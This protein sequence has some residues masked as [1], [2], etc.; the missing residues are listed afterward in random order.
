MLVS[1]RFGIVWSGA[2]VLLAAAAL[3]ACSGNGPTLSPDAGSGAGAGM[4]SLASVTSY[5]AANA[6]ITTGY[7]DKE[8]APDHFEVRAKGSIVTPPEH[9]EKIALARAAEIGVEQKFP[10]FRT[11]PFTHVILC[12]QAKGATHKG[13]TVAA[14][15]APVVA[16]DVIYAKDA[17]DVSYLPAAET[18]ERLRAELAQGGVSPESKSAS[19]A[20]VQA[21]CGK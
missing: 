13:S 14:E 2:V 20:A 3:A 5:G 17:G 1:S 21:K 11:G 12:N 8:L 4:V 15:R 7:S 9:L 6:I 16:I 19:A 10:F 18:F